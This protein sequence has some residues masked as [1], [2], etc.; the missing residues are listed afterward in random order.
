MEKVKINDTL[1]ISK[2]VAG[3]M[4]TKDA[5]ME[6][7]KLLD[8]AER[9]IDIG[10]TTFDHAP[11]YGGYQC[12]R[13]FGDAVL[14]KKPE[15]RRKMQI[16]TKAGIVLP[17]VDNNKTIL[18]NSSKQEIKKETENSLRRLG[19]DYIDVLLIHR[20]DILAEPLQT[21]EALEELIKEGKV[22]AVGVS[23]FQPSQIEMLQSYLTLKI[24]VNQVE[25]SVKNPENLF[26]GITDDALI[27]RIPLM[28]WSPLG[29]GSIF[30]GEDEQSMR[31]RKTIGQIAEKYQVSIDVIMYAWLF[32]HPAKIAAIT[33]TMNFER[34]KRAVDAADMKLTYDEWYRILEASR[35]FPVP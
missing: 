21:A 28:A 13:I 20:P 35:G 30:T 16:I 27:R 2:I 7:E 26:N 10:V 6:G 18:Y 33:G 11:V 15:L 5:D 22:L 8:F 29:G 19:T 4:R 25:M 14:R 1:Y 34:I 3:C 31:L 24:A 32:R 9:C 17:G 23:N 12:D